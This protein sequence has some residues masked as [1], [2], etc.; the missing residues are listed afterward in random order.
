MGINIK[1]VNI[2]LKITKL[3]GYLIIRNIEGQIN[4][5]NQKI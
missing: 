2:I 4:I 5:I 3:G 1:T